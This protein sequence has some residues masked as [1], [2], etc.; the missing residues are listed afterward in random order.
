M[1]WNE[2]RKL[3]NKSQK[4][5]TENN[6]KGKKQVEKKRDLFDK[7]KNSETSPGTKIENCDKPQT[8]ISDCFDYNSSF[9]YIE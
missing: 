7:M 2:L 9:L 8:W 3:T 1:N 4:H 6:K 5:Y